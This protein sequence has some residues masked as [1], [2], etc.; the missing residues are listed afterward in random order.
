MDH[1][2]VGVRGADEAWEVLVD[3]PGGF[4][5]KVHD[6]VANDAGDKRHVRGGVETLEQGPEMRETGLLC[7]VER[8]RD[9]TSWVASMSEGGRPSGMVA[10]W[11]LGSPSRVRPRHGSGAGGGGCTLC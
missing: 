2:L 4:Q 1:E 11:K 5:G 7:P 6:V 9:G 8:Q 10:K 3:L